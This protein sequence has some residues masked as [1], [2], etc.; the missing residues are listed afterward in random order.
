M[1]ITTP[2]EPSDQRH[3]QV[4]A[5]VSNDSVHIVKHDSTGTRSTPSRRAARSRCRICRQMY[6]LTDLYF[7]AALKRAGGA[8]RQCAAAAILHRSRVRSFPVAL[9]GRARAR[10]EQGRAASRL[11]SR[12]RRR[13]VRFAPSH[14]HVLGSAID[15]QGPGAAAHR[16]PEVEAIGERFA[17]SRLPAG[18]MKQLSVRDTARATIGAAT[19]TSTTAG[20]WRAARAAGQ[21]HALR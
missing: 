3:R 8:G 2:S 14:A 1:D 17:R 18:G 12:L 6:S 16:Q 5:D 4:I 10:A 19:F 7:G 21:R 9:R 11:A 20:R 13:D 15:V